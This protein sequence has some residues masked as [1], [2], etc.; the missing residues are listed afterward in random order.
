MSSVLSSEA[1]PGYRGKHAPIQTSRRLGKLGLKDYYFDMNKK[2]TRATDPHSKNVIAASRDARELILNDGTATYVVHST[3]PEKAEAAMHGEGLRVKG[4]WREPATPYLAE[5]G[6]MLAGPDEKAAEFRNF[7][8]LAY[9]YGEGG[10][11]CSAKL[12]FM[13]GHSNPGTSMNEDPFEGTFLESADG[14]NIRQ[15]STEGDGEYVLPTERLM[16]YFD[17]EGGAFV[18]NPNFAPPP[19]QAPHLS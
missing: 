13:F 2:G 18:P 6:L 12:V 1:P 14:V 8:Y 11:E 5:T 7:E 17:L 15:I 3:T 19:N 10:I 16:G 9:R 4:K